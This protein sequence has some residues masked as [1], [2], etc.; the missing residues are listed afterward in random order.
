MTI[1]ALN[2]GAPAEIISGR[3]QT[4]CTVASVKWSL[5]ISI[6][7][8]SSRPL[9]HK[10]SNTLIISW[11]HPACC[12]GRIKTTHK[13][14]V[15][16]ANTWSRGGSW[17][18][19]EIKSVHVYDITSSG[20]VELRG[21]SC[22]EKTCYSLHPVNTSVWIFHSHSMKRP[23]ALFFL[24]ACVLSI[25]F[26]TFPLVYLPTKTSIHYLS[27]LYPCRVV[28]T[29][30]YPIWHWARRGVHPGQVT[31]SLRGWHTDRHI[32]TFMPT[33]NHHLT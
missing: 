29:G 23:Q 1:L 12:S 8:S 22:L 21:A 19:S 28:G 26:S 10:A 17:V 32:H 18:L 9:N 25:H 6:P 20:G 16:E 7:T 13:D 4:V 15:S 24:P 31:S 14:S 5:R 33:I 2:H 27:P 3:Q 30:A 11:D